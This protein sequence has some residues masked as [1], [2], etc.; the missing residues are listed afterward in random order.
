MDTESG[1][2]TNTKLNTG[3]ACHEKAGFWISEY[4]I[5]TIPLSPESEI[6][7]L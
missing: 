3:W 1:V 5:S 4:I 7:K 2:I 6:L